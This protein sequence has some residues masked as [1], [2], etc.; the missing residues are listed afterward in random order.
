M[1]SPA[2]LQVD[3]SD[4]GIGAALLQPSL[5]SMESSEIEWQPV[6]YSSSSLTPR[7]KRYGKIEKKT[8]AIVHVFHNSDQLLFGKADIIIHTDHKP[9]EAIFKRSLTSAPS[10]PSAKY[11]NLYTAVQLPGRV[12]QVLNSSYR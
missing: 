1:N 8:L 10:P 3:A 9:L 12:S 4:Y 11:A 6:A 5:S 2:V 7:E